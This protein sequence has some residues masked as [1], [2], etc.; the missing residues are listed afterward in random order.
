MEQDILQR[1]CDE[2]THVLAIMYKHEFL[3]KDT[4]ITMTGNGSGAIFKHNDFEI[5]KTRDELI[6]DLLAKNL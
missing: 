2:D 6:K 3:P 4:N 5:E 1:L